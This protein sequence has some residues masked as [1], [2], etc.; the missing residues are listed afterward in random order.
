M[1][2][3]PT[4]INASSFAV[5]MSMSDFFLQLIRAE[6]RV[7]CEHGQFQ[8]RAVTGSGQVSPSAP[9]PVVGYNSTKLV[10]NDSHDDIVWPCKRV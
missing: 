4:R 5:N 1:E 7:K 8:T 2:C 9:F 10:M 3:E 6:K